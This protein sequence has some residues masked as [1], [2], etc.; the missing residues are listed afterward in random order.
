MC[1]EDESTTELVEIFW[2]IRLEEWSKISLSAPSEASVVYPLRGSVVLPKRSIAAERRTSSSS[3]VNFRP[4]R[5]LSLRGLILARG[6]PGVS[7]ASSIMGTAENGQTRWNS[8]SDLTVDGLM[9]AGGLGRP[10]IACFIV[11]CGNP[12]DPRARRLIRLSSPFLGQ[13]R[14]SL[15]CSHCEPCDYVTKL[16]RCQTLLFVDQRTG[17]RKIKDCGGL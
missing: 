14:R 13:F 6:A 17:T 8:F 16:R 4:L 5:G 11:S 1:D 9:I 2:W 10:F 12:L 3:K 7:G 15:R